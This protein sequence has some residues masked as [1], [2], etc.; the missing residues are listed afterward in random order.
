MPRCPFPS[1]SRRR[2]WRRRQPAAAS[3]AWSSGRSRR[4]PPPP[5][6]PFRK[7]KAGNSTR[8]VPPG[9]PAGPSA[10]TASAQVLQ[11]VPPGSVLSLGLTVGPTVPT[12]EASLSPPDAE[13]MCQA[14]I[15]PYQAS[16]F[17]DEEGQPL[18]FPG[19]S[20]ICSFNTCP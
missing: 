2:S 4:C 9:A 14:R 7:R 8:P 13:S 3:P 1:R 5:S 20:S 16:R 19:K 11:R 17:A 18:I 15:Q 10:A 6:R 12:P